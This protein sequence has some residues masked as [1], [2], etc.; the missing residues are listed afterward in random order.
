MAICCLIHGVLSRN[1]LLTGA[2]VDMMRGVISILSIHADTRFA[3][4]RVCSRDESW[5]SRSKVLM[6]SWTAGRA[7]ILC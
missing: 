4:S 1:G 6:S 2:S 7:R 5:C 3:T